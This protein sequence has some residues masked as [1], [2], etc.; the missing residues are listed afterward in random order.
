MSLPQDL[1][2]NTLHQ[3]RDRFAMREIGSPYK[4]LTSAFGPVGE[5]RIFAGETVAKMV[6]I[7]MAVPQFGLDSHMIFAFTPPDSPIPHF[8][9]DSVMNAPDFAFH[10]DLIPR[11]DM[12]AHLE[13]ME[14]CF[15]PLTESFD[16]AAQIEGLKPARLGP[17]QY[18]IMSAW[19]LAYRANEAAFGA[20]QTPVSAYLEHWARLVE[21]GIAPDVTEG[22]TR[23]QLA[24]RD[25]RNRNI[26][27]NPAVDRV[28]AQVDRLL[29]AETSAEMRAV[30]INQGVEAL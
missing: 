1:S 28:W 13:Y 14:T 5:M 4:V 16:A 9:L 24:E 23:E 22:V 29:G 21:G 20:I 27:F 10:L 7:S 15:T 11:V 19:M 2:L 18:A 25:R 3:I 6:Y 26:I 12:G 17:R 8:T 30:L